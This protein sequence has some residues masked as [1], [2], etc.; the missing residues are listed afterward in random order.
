MLRVLTDIIFFQQPSESFPNREGQIKYNIVNSF[1]YTKGWAN[2]SGVGMVKLPK[3]V[4]VTDKNGR[5]VSLG[6]LNMNIGGFTDNPIFLRGDKVVIRWGYAY[7]DRLGNEVSQV[8]DVFS[9]YISS[10]TSKKPIVLEIEDNMYLL[11]RA[12]ASGGNNGFFSGKSYTVETM[13]Q[14]MVSNAGLDISVNTSQQ[15]SIGDFWVKGESIAQV[16]ARLK[17]DYKFEGYFYGNELRTGS[18]RYNPSDAINHYLNGRPAVFQFQ[19]NIISDQLEYMRKDDLTLSAV[20]INTIEETGAGTT[21]DGHQKKKKKRLEVLVTFENGSDT[22]KVFVGSKEKKIPPNTGGERRTLHFI[23]AKTTDELATLATNEL[24]KYYYT[25][26]KGKF[27]VFGLP[28]IYFGDYVD[29][30]DPLLPE[31]CGRYVVRS[32]KYT[33]GVGGLRQ[34]IELDYLINRLDVNGKVI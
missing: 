29:I 30:I 10:V 24:R 27:V 1:E 32:V 18:F 15:T 9:G 19:K 33:G 17:K 25:G 16:L 22:P 31:R 12:T 6:G 20:A 7:F 13:L 14:E 21:K 34:E 3:N 2:H 11:K 26:L 5:R 8:V 28:F 23:G 4:Y